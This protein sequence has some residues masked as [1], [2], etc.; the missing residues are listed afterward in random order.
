M[1]PA[2]GQHAAGD[3][4]LG[5]VVPERQHLVGMRALAFEVRRPGGIPAALAVAGA[6]LLA[7]HRSGVSLRARAFRG[8]GGR[9]GVVGRGRAGAQREGDGQGEG[10]AEGG[11]VHGGLSVGGGAPEPYASKH[12]IRFG[13]GLVLMLSVVIGFYVIGKVHHALHTPLMSV[14]NAISGIVVV[15]ALLQITDSNLV[16]QILAAVGVLLASINVFGGF[17]VTSRMLKMFTRGD[18]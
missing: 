18:K 13:F 6:E 7:L 9:G 10:G 12:A 17:A 2:R 1:R 15:A 11:A 16:V 8:R 4:G 3:Q 14:T 5:A